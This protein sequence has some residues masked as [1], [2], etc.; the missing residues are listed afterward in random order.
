MNISPSIDVNHPEY[1]FAPGS[2]I[3]YTCCGL[4]WRSR[5][6]E[7]LVDQNYKL[8]TTNRTNYLDRVL[9]NERLTTLISHDLNHDQESMNDL[10]ERLRFRVNYD[11]TN[12]SAITPEKFALIINAIYEVKLERSNATLRNTKTRMS[13]L[14]PKRHPRNP[15]KK[16]R[17]P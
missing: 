13:H 14:Q 3:N 16:T 9:A 7:Y 5:S 15:N 10:F 17:L 11:I 4:C 1:H 8:R 6:K 2:D 12:G